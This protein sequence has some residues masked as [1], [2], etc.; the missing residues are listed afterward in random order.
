M[1]NRLLFPYLFLLLFYCLFN[2]GCSTNSSLNEQA[3]TNIPLPEHP[4]PDFERKEWINLNGNWQFAFDKEDQGEQQ[5]WA[6]GKQE[7]SLQITV[8]FPWGSKLS[9]VE[10]EA[11]IAWYER[12]IT[13]PEDWKGKRV[14]LVVGA[15]DWLTTGWIDGQK[16]GSFQGGYTPF[17]FDLTGHVQY[18]K[19]QK[20]T[21]KVDDSPH[22]FKLFGKQG[23]GDAKGIWQT[24]YMEARAPL[25]LDYIHFSPDI[26]NN[27]VA[28]E[29]G[30]N[31][32]PT[33]PASLNLL[34]SNS[35]NA[36]SVDI[37]AGQEKINF[38]MDMPNA[39]LWTL[40]DPHLYEAMVT[41][42]DQQ[43][44]KDEVSTYFGMRKISVVD[45]P[46]T[47]IPYIALNNKP[48]YLQ[49]ALDQAYHPEGFYTFPTDEF[50]RE[51]IQR[52]KDIGLNGQRIH[53][54]VEVPRKL[55]WAD[56][57][58]MLIMA[59]VPN[60]WGE[61]GPE[62]RQETETALRE[63]IKRDYNHP[64]IFSW[65]VFNETWGLFS[66]SEDGK[67]V[68]LP[69]T[70]NWVAEMYRLAKS[71]DG[72]RLVEDNSPCNY[73]HVETDINSWHI[74]LPGYEWKTKLDEFS[75]KTFPGSGWNFVEGYK[76][77][78]QPNINSECGNVWGYEGSTGDVDWS[79][80]YHIMMNEFRS[81]PKIAGWLY[82]EHHDVINEWNGYWKYDRSPKFTGLEA[83][84]PGM[85]LNDLHSLVYLAPQNYLAEEVKPGASVKVPLKVSVMEEGFE[86]MPASIETELVLYDQ[87]GEEQSLNKANHNGF[88]LSAWDTKD[89][90]PLSVKMPEQPG[91]AV[92]R[93]KLKDDK[94]KVLHHNFTTFVVSNGQ[95]V[96]DQKV[97]NGSDNLRVLRFSPEK[98]SKAEWSEKQWNVLDGLK[99]NGAGAG[100]F[101]YT[102]PLPKDLDL[103]QVKQA[104]LKLEAS[105]KQLLGKDKEGEK[106]EGGDY[107]RGKG[108][109]DPGKN[110]NAYP[111]TDTQK[112]PSKVR[113]LVNGQVVGVQDLEDDPA[114]HQGILSW[115]AQPSDR[116]LHEAGSYGYLISVDIPMAVLQQARQ[117]GKLTIRLQVDEELP[118]G[119]AIYG[120]RF[121]R[122]PVDP[123]VVF[124]L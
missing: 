45:L 82:T 28:V 36:M 41:L 56:K 63:M 48:I 26:D 21:L 3:T 113:I 50:M 110:P 69:E 34:L 90:Q 51:E 106:E 122:Y 95:A 52:S 78:R 38:T 1:K 100:Y 114:D 43:G 104:T 73:D 33:A 67:N 94:G 16:V 49:L 77:G 119:L 60:S 44:Q 89:L 107:M 40:E 9:G 120:Q 58:G 23:Y 35:K 88:T 81:H 72:T 29:A 80:D 87:L 5:G 108:L 66:K 121:G 102:V 53:I 10:N 2:S 93:M 83:I 86:N 103:A 98:F 22:D 42:T 19:E 97:N 71:L 65:V 109:H 92:L 59:D 117:E 8:P 46:G 123:M 54:K 79:W 99:V 37:P 39:K 75:Q 18:G 30:L 4:R 17:S 31:Q 70:Q 76:Q 57:L 55:Y 91:L 24:V 115:H 96:K 13:V 11:D 105:A 27:K 124:K 14:H 7:F 25:A 32:E 62:M 12:S 64:S 111:M 68:Y 84:M 116:T 47:D 61:P 6:E 20:L 74:Y 15:S 85:K 118:G 112:F 101:E